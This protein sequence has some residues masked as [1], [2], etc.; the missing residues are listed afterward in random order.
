MRGS[1]DD[2]RTWGAVPEYVWPASGDRVWVMGRW[3]F[4]CGHPAADSRQYVKFSTEI[5]PPRALVT[6]R[7]NHTALSSLNNP[8]S[9]RW[10]P[11]TGDPVTLPP[12]AP[13]TGPTNV[14]ATEADVFVSG[15]GGGA[16]DLCMLMG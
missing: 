9:Q 4:D 3:V 10:L 2:D 8:L 16:N 6:Y 13:N 7:L 5:H 11:V 12:D 15:N 14:P 1:D